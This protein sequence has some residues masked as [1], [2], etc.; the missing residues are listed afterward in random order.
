LTTWQNLKAGF[1]IINFP[2]IDGFL[3]RCWFP[4]F[5][6]TV[7]HLGTSSRTPILILALSPHC[8]NG[9]RSRRA[10]C[11]LCFAER[12]EWGEVNGPGGS[13]RVIHVS[14][15]SP[16]LDVTPHR[17]KLFLSQ[18]NKSLFRSSL[19]PLGEAACARCAP[20]ATLMLTA[21]L[22]RHRPVIVPPSP[23][24]S[25]LH[26]ANFSFFKFNHCSFSHPRKFSPLFAALAD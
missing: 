7:R 23:C 25:T 11:V 20:A 19:S 15:S 21:S 6:L 9:T 17:D 24:S 3:P 12:S 5:S 18:S 16:R 4:T 1:Y 2:E 10:D 8:R 14:H 26:R 13:Q 22:A